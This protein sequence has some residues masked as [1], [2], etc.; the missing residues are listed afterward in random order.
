MYST[1]RTCPSAAVRSLRFCA[2]PTGCHGLYTALPALQ[3]PLHMTGMTVDLSS[4]ATHFFCL[5][6]V[7]LY[8]TNDLGALAMSL[9]C[10]KAVRKSSK[11]MQEALPH[12]EGARWAHRC[13]RVWRRHSPGLG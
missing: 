2:D 11:S 5:G 10:G 3:A 8:V 1:S 13:P 9:G 7:K 12:R 4:T 6:S